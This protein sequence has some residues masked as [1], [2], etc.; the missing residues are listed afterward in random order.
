MRTCTAVIE[1][2]KES[3]G[4]YAYV[5]Q[6]HC[7]KLKKLLP[8]GMSFPFDFGYITGTKGE[9]GAPLDIIVIAEFKSFA[10]CAMDCRIIGA[11][12]AE[13]KEKGK[14][15]RNDRFIGVPEMSVLYSRINSIS[16]LPI[17]L[18]QQL[19]E[20]F[21][22]YNKAEKKIFRILQQLDAA[23]AYKVLSKNL[24]EMH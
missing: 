9:D 13:Q 11:I 18:L 12:K 20:F 1:T 7:F 17:K 4:K 5:E 14:L 16:Q 6:L 15:I 19:E 22:N 2:P 21:V 3:P 24:Q 8:Q 10:G 23:R